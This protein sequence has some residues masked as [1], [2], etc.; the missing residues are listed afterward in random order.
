MAQNISYPGPGVALLLAVDS[1]VESGDPVVIGTAIR[2]VALTDRDASGN[3]TVKLPFMFVATLAV[4]G[5][6]GNG[7]ATVSIGDQLYLD[8]TAVNKDTGGKALGVA[9][10]AVVSGQTTEI[11]VGF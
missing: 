2:G 9:L 11:L 4:V 1:G 8:G 6:D 10:E 5:A 3:A 7:N